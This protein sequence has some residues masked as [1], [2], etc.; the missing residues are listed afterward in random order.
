MSSKVKPRMRLATHLISFSILLSFVACSKIVPLRKRID[1]LS[2]VVSISACRLRVVVPKFLQAVASD[3]T[4]AKAVGGAVGNGGNAVGDGTSNNGGTAAN[5]SMGG[6]V[7]GEDR[8]GFSGGMAGSDLGAGMGGATGGTA[9]E[10]GFG[11]AGGAVVIE[12]M[13]L[14]LHLDTRCSGIDNIREVRLTGPD[15]AWNP[16]GG[17]V[18]ADVDG[19]GIYTMTLN[20]VPDHDIQYK[21]IVNGEF[22]ATLTGEPSMPIGACTPLTNPSANPPFAHRIHTAG[23]GE[24]TDTWASCVEVWSELYPGRQDD[25]QSRYPMHRCQR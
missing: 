23:S 20:D 11:G 10:G 15:W 3:Q 18:A 13:G 4:D 25:H 2:T 22:E 21:W 5:E 1:N 8:G 14:S 17:P 16:A 6:G 24:R 12:P 9:D 7:S 19:D